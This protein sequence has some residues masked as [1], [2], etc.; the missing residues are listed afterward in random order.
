VPRACAGELHTVLKIAVAN[1]LVTAIQFV[2]DQSERRHRV[3]LVMPKVRRCP[4]YEKVRQP[5]WISL[6]R[7]ISF[8][9]PRSSA[10]RIVPS[11]ALDDFD[12]KKTDRPRREADCQIISVQDGK[13]EQF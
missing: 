9:D 6:P 11:P 12:E 13:A 2:S 8:D 7:T 4:G 10:P 3:I 5:R 1:S